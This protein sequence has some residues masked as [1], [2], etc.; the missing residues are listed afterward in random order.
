M[1]LAE[2]KERPTH[3]QP[4]SREGWSASARKEEQQGD[5]KKRRPFVPPVETEVLDRFSKRVRARQASD[6]KDEA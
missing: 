3:L 6:A 1:R 5:Q 2:R 4:G